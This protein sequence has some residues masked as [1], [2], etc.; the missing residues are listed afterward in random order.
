MHGEGWK[1]RA[2]LMCR[3]SGLQD[4]AQRSSGALTALK[5]TAY[6]KADVNLRVQ[7]DRCG[8]G[9]K[10]KSE[11]PRCTCLPQAGSG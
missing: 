8:T 4:S 7:G 10:T 9:R 11:I 2:Q 5:R 1:A 6:K 3:A